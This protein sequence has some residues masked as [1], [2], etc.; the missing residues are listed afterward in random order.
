MRK[1]SSLSI[2]FPSLNDAQI[3]P[4]LIYKT[5][6]IA[7][8]VADKFEVIVINDGST[9]DTKQVLESLKKK[10][11]NLKPV[12]HRK[13]SG[14]GGAL[15]AGFKH[16]TK[17]WIFYTDGDGQYDPY[18]LMLLTRKANKNIDVVNGYKMQRIDNKLRQAI[19]W[20]YNK[21][22]RKIYRIPISD[23]DCDFRLIRKSFL[24]K[25]KLTCKSGMICLELILKLSDSGARFTETGVSHYSRRFGYSQFFRPKHLFNTLV[26]HLTFYKKYKLAKN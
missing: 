10:Y 1:L 17:E 4:Y 23:V 12:H 22:L 19:G 11:K 25:I 26:E 24:R 8:K 13:N 6:E 7:P 20:L 14:Y 5:Y 9:D 18:D 21:L 16:A 15:I 3:L 2:F